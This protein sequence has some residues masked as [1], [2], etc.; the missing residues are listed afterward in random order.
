MT[1]SYYYSFATDKA[2]RTPTLNITGNLELVFR[3]KLPVW[4]TGGTSMALVSNGFYAWEV[5]NYLGNFYLAI[6]GA[7]QGS[8]SIANLG[9]TNNVCYW[10][11]VT[12]NTTTGAIDWFVQPYAEDVPTSWGTAKT[13]AGT[14]AAG[15][16]STT[17]RDLCIGARPHISDNTLAVFLT[18][19]VYDVIVR[20]NGVIKFEW[21]GRVDYAESGAFV[22]SSGQTVTIVGAILQGYQVPNTALDIVNVTINATVIEVVNVSVNPSGIQTVIVSVDDTAS[23]TAAIAAL[24]GRVTALETATAKTA[25]TAVTFQNSWV[26]NVSGVETVAYRK[27]G[28]IVTLRGM[29]MTGAV[30]S[31]VFTLPVGYRSPLQLRFPINSNG[32]Y[33]QCRVMPDGTVIAQAGASAGFNFDGVSFSTIA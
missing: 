2:L 20:E 12:R 9:L 15:A 19:E 13:D 30:P 28:D 11:K 18:G 17:T 4:D 24:T 1:I 26:N 32:A 14:Q 3:A 8:C 29:A 16:I 7:N 6:N 27:I 23:N 33:G 5:V 31:V 25:W 22:A 10:F 21:R